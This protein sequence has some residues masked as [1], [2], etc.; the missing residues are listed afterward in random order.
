ME[1]KAVLHVLRHVANH[2][3][4]LRHEGQLQALE[5][6]VGQIVDREALERGVIGVVGKRHLLA[7]HNEDA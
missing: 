7:Q 6:W 5:C 3:G 2:A 4:V 1:P